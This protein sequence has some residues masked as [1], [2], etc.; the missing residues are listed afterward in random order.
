MGPRFIR[1][2][3]VTVA[4]LALCVIPMRRVASPLYAQTV[5]HIAQAL[6]IT[7]GPTRQYLSYGDQHL[8]IDRRDFLR[9][10]F[11]DQDVA[12]SGYNV[13][14]IWMW[15]AAASDLPRRR[16]IRLAALATSVSGAAE[17]LSLACSAAA[18]YR[19]S[20]AYSVSIG[21]EYLGGT[22]AISNLAASFG[23]LGLLV[24]PAVFAVAALPGFAMLG[25]SVSRPGPESKP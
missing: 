11:R 25:L 15:I 10:Y 21:V 2:I 24:V 19:E 18:W 6:V 3:A 14:V 1:H 12:P 17:V 5:M 16:R 8:E 20:A 7:A 22:T 9:E 4:L 23:H 13:L